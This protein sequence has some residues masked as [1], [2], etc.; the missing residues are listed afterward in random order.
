MS[1]PQRA[2]KS[3]TTDPTG[4][5]LSMV[6][7]QYVAICEDD[8]YLSAQASVGQ[9]A[10]KNKR[11]SLAS[12]GVFWRNSCG[13]WRRAAVHALGK[14]GDVVCRTCALSKAAVRRSVKRQADVE[15]LLKTGFTRHISLHARDTLRKKEQQ[16]RENKITQP[17]RPTTTRPTRPRKARST[18][19]S[20]R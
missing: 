16:T 2:R 11:C 3:A 6:S 9:K 19:T 13:S 17:P 1:S 12:G 8:E 10:T 7:D 18:G 20:C 5:L 4:S 15:L 14:R